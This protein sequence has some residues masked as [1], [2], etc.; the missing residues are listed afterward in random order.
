VEVDRRRGDADL[1]GD[2]AQREPFEATGLSQDPI[3]RG[4]QLG[5]QAGALTLGIADAPPALGRI[6]RPE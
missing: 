1:S 6:V 2:A 4:D 3:G 5:A